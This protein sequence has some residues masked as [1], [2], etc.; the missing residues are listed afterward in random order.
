M[1]DILS[2]IKNYNIS[3]LKINLVELLARQLLLMWFKR[4][5]FSLTQVDLTIVNSKI[6]EAKIMSVEFQDKT[7]FIDK[8]QVITLVFYALKS[9]PWWN[10]IH[11]S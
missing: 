6:D 2:L 5:Y 10:I 4:H 3:W 9:L 11:F 7:A 1:A 8:D